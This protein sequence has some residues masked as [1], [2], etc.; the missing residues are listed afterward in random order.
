MSPH[1]LKVSR[2]WQEWLGIQHQNKP[3]K[4]KLYII[5]RGY[6]SKSIVTALNHISG[7]WYYDNKNK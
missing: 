7:F 4:C 6:R 3:Y 2:S 1:F 5:Y